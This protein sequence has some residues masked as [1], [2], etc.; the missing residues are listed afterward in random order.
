MMTIAETLKEIHDN[1]QK[2]HDAGYKKGNQTGNDNGYVQAYDDYWTAF[3][4]TNDKE[5]TSGRHR[6]FGWDINEKTFRPQKDFTVTNCYRM[7]SWA[8]GDFDL[9]DLCEKRGI[10]MI[11]AP[12]TAN[13]SMEI[14]SNS[15]VIRIGTVDASAIT[16]TS[17]SAMFAWGMSKLKTIEKL[18]ISEQTKYVSWFNEASGLQNLTIEGTIGQN[19]FNVQWSKL[20]SKESIVSIINAL[21]V[22]TSG[23]TVTL[24][25]TAVNNAFGIDVDDVS[26]WGEGTEYYAL[27]HSKDNWTISYV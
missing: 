24:S 27:R 23:L 3:H 4:L 21:S 11:I 9:V 5:K 13:A 17:Y 2:V 26:T 15:S 25:K 22:T 20:L 7:F 1:V 19:G 6:F 16:Q 18:I 14:F 12:E 8:Q 10:T